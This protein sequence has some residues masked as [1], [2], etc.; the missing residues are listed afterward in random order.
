MWLAIERQGRRRWV[1]MV[2][3][4]VRGRVRLFATVESRPSCGGVEESGGEKT[5]VDYAIASVS[6]PG[7]GA[8]A[9]SPSPAVR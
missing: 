7:V 8:G 3:V 6:V 4:E 2:E 5:L 1:V 9:G